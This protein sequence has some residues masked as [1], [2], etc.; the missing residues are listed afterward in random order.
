LP[1]IIAVNRLG[2][3][4]NDIDE[5]DIFEALFGKEKYVL[6]TLAGS[7]S[8]SRDPDGLWIGHT[9]P[10]NKKVSAALIISQL[11]P[12]T[13][14]VSNPKLYHNPWS[15]QKFDQNLWTGEQFIPNERKTSLE[16]IEGKIAK[17]I[18]ELDRDSLEG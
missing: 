10:R 7:T 2:D 12:W 11:K 6:N 14:L 13:I 17:E 15:N 4:I 8:M 3:Y 5:I 18:L 1:Y 9:G 16:K